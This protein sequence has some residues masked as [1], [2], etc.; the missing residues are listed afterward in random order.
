MSEAGVNEESRAI[1]RYLRNIKIGGN[2]GMYRV[3]HFDSITST[4]A[5]A[6]DMAALGNVKD[7]VVVAR[8]QTGG[9][10]RKGDFW[11][12]TLGGLWFSILWQPKFSPQR[13]P[14]FSV[15]CAKALCRSFGRALPGAYFEV[16]EPNDVLARSP[17]GPL[18]K[19][20]G[21]ILEGS[22]NNDLY[23]WLTCGVGIN[24][25]NEMPQELLSQAVSLERISNKPIPRMPLLRDAIQ[26][27]EAVRRRF[28]EDELR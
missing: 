1:E 28:E 19:V 2:G 18:K 5:A 17:D 21:V 13:A 8:Q 7:V 4:Q 27:L 25:N 3:C 16:K 20:C 14:D 23:D 22:V 12:S 24:V 15:A 26:G 6:K 9:Y 11:H 10:G